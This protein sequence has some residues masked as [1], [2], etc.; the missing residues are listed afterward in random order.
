[1]IRLVAV[2]VS[3]IVLTVGAGLPF[4]KTKVCQEVSVPCGVKV[5]VALFVVKLVTLIIDGGGH[6]KSAY[7][8]TV[9]LVNP[10]E[11]SASSE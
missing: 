4:S 1:M 9:L 7:K 10:E 8:V 2:A 3:P 5:I 6:V 11:Q